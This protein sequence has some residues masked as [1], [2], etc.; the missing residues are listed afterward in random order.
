MQTAEERRAERHRSWTF[1]KKTT[2]DDAPDTS[3]LTTQERFTLLWQITQDTWAFT[4]T[5][6]H[7]YRSS[8]YIG[9]VLRGER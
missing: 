9:R 6:I 1:E 4:G 2:Q 5:P 3:H 7:E 8:R